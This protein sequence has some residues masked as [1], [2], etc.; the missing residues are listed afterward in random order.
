MNEQELAKH[1][2]DTQTK[3]I[4]EMSARTESFVHQIAGVDITVFPKVY[5]GGI[6]SELTSQ[7]MGDVSGKSVLDLCTGTGIVAIKAAQAEAERVVAVDLNPEAVENAKFNAHKFRLSQIEVQEGSLFEPV[8][9]ETFDVITINPP[10]TGKKPGNKT[11]IC[12][13][14]EDNKTTKQFFVEFRKHLNPK[15]N[16]YLAWADFGS[17]ELV[18]Q[19]AAENDVEL[20]LVESQKTKSGLATFL[21]YK[22]KTL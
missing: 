4:A 2:L 10:Y 9:E 1:H 15:G 5:P 20:K 8:G 14:D 6:D 22:L 21:V 3:E 17:I 13:W 7:A 19:F 18:Q 11:E 12:F 16:A